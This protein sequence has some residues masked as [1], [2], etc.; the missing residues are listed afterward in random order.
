[1]KTTL[2]ILPYRD[3]YF[4]KEYGFAVRDTQ[5]IEII[6]R[7]R[8]FDDVIVINRPVSLHE[9]ILLG[10]V[11]KI[12]WPN[13]K[14]VS[15][16]SFDLLGPLFGR[17]WA[18]RCYNKTLQKV[19]AKY[20]DPDNRIIILDFSPFAIIHPE[21]IGSA[22][23]WHDMIDNFKK[24]NRFS[25]REKELVGIKYRHVS[26]TYDLVT[27]V[28][29]DALEEVECKKRVLQNGLFDID[30]GAN[31]IRP[32]YDFGFI[33]FITNKMDI[34]FIEY[35]RNMGYSVIIYGDIF[36][37]KIRQSLLSIGVIMGGR[38]KYEEIS[39]I[40]QSF[41]VGLIP[42]IRKLEHD[43]FPLKMYEYLL[44]N[45]PCI[46]SSSYGVKNDYVYD[47]SLGRPDRT[48]LDGIIN[49]SGSEQISKS[50]GEDA[51]LRT[52]VYKIINEVINENK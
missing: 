47:Y 51:I 10:K 48:Q 16:M 24:H 42:Y 26:K 34:E 30:K 8:M 15:S 3:S 39:P 4:V 1:M 11:K 33:G 37:R 32:K 35:I 19:V 5:I 46:S 17:R 18:T 27:G 43:G 13:I 50:I 21:R 29:G 22:F 40:V 38:F 36:D 28:S 9:Y 52:Q 23:L 31:N 45:R 2:I 25:K 49:L 12:D 20:R 6:S 7:S 14:T 41:K 44:R